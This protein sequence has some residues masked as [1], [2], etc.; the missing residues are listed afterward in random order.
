VATQ[1]EIKRAIDKAKVR[2]GEY[3]WDIIVAWEHNGSDLEERPWWCK[4]D[5]RKICGYPKD[6]PWRPLFWALHKAFGLI[7][8][9]R[10][11]TRY[12]F[13]FPTGPQ[14]RARMI[15][16]SLSRTIGS[17]RRAVEL[18]RAGRAAGAF[19]R[20]TNEA[21][22]LESAKLADKYQVTI[23]EAL[24]ASAK[25]DAQILEDEVLEL[26]EGVGE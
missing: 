23:N 17:Q 11:H 20:L 2:F 10:Y 16:Y 13:S 19:R 8:R 9:Y 7:Y 14:D 6:Y 26:L 21:L 3:Y 22:E 4:S 15:R 12:V 18:L 24:L 5:I 1:E 25:L